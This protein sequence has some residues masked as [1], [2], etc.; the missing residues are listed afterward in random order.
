MNVSTPTENPNIPE[1]LAAQVVAT[2]NQVS[3]AEGE[4]RRLQALA[5]SSQY[6]I[7]ELVKQ[8]VEITAQ[9]EVLQNKSNDLTSEIASLNITKE[10]LSNDVRELTVDADK[11]SA[12]IE[13]RSEIIRIK[14]TD[15]S[16]R[17]SQLDADTQHLIT[18]RDALEASKVEHE[19]KVKKLKDALL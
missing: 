16:I 3:L 18:E 2:R 6:T 14:E 15:V 17:Q 12:D 13:D 11:L 7:D 4:V 10:A 5:T 1:K 9:I 8:K 19:K